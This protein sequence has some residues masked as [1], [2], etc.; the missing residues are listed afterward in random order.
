M[1]IPTV[2]IPPTLGVQMASPFEGN[3]ALSSLSSF[4]GDLATHEKVTAP[5]PVS[6]EPEDELISTTCS[7]LHEGSCR[8]LALSDSLC[9]NSMCTSHGVG[10]TSY[11]WKTEGACAD[12]VEARVVG[13]SGRFYDIHVAAGRAIPEWTF[14]RRYRDFKTLD[15]HVRE[16]YSDLPQIP[17]RSIFFRRH[18]KPGFTH[19]FEE[20]LAAYVKALVS[21]PSAIAEPAVQ[22][23]LGIVGHVDDD[24]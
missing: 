17:Q 14:I 2:Q 18:F 10:P 21:N 22:R 8:T 9:T 23:F 3:A 20:G 15:A 16:K 24:E 13:R 12:A 1:S 4:E 5:I 11:S 7:W 6:D 19:R